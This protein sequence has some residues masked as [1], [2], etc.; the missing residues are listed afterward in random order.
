MMNQDFCARQARPPRCAPAV[1]DGTVEGSVVDGQP[2]LPVWLSWR[3]N[4]PVGTR[5]LCP[6]GS[7]S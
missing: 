3:M 5:W 6:F 4:Y 2:A 1:V 7:G